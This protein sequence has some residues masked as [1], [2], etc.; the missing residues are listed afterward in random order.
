M[1]GSAK[2]RCLHP[3]DIEDVAHSAAGRASVPAPIGF[4]GTG[5]D[6][7]APAKP[8]FGRRYQNLHHLRAATVSR[9]SVG[10]VC[11]YAMGLLLPST[12]TWMLYS[13]P[14]AMPNG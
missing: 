10:S 1:S 11:M 7:H 3:T 8:Q 2:V 4:N 9:W 5:T 14:L 12:A 6:S 13:V